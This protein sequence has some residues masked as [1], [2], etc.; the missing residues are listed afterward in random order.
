MAGFAVEESE[1]RNVSGLKVHEALSPDIGF[2][3][4]HNR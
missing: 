4:V 3:C 1:T 2:T